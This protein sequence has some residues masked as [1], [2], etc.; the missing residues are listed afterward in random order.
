MP[1]W[2][3]IALASFV[4]AVV[5]GFLLPPFVP[6]NSGIFSSI[7]RLVASGPA[8]ALIHGVHAYSGDIFLI[9]TLMHLLEYLHKKSYLLYRTGAWAWLILLAVLAVLTVFSGF[10]SMGS[11]ESLSAIEIFQS[12][13]KQIPFAGDALAR[14]LFGNQALAAIYAHH[15]STFTILSVLLIYIHLRRIKSTSYATLYVLVLLVIVVLIWPPFIGHPPDS[16][17]PVVKGPWYFIGL[18][19]ML[20]W[21]PAWLAGVVLPLGMVLLLGFLPFNRSWARVMV[22]LILAILAVYFI[23]AIIGTW[24]RGAGWQLLMR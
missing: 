6:P 2:G 3:D 12:L 5:S 14:L 8:G 1:G 7:S 23:E 24:L 17:Q 20:S 18:Q 16:V 15:A 4:I 11:K 21:L 22:Y 9:A 10:L 13:L 19:E